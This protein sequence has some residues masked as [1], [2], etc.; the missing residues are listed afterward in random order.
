MKLK[1][2]T[3]VKPGFAFH[4]AITPD[5]EGAI[6]VVQ[7]RDAQVGQDFIQAED[8]VKISFKP[9]RT[10]TY[11]LGGDIILT[12]RGTGVGAFRAAV[13]EFN[14]DD[15]NILPSSSVF[16]I[17]IKDMQKLMPQFLALFLNSSNGQRLILQTASGS[18]VQTISRREL[19]Q[20]DL[21]IPPLIVQKN[22]VALADNILKQEQISKRKN[23]LKRD[24]INVTIS[25][26]THNH[27]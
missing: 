22:L 7:A 24:L 21:S 16:V 20:I 5:E 26:L 23:Q 3:E 4:G 18:N 11:V 10:R 27:N 8:L 19:E 1:D 17:R 2:I 6:F 14:I 15:C 13:M 9:V 25:N 12:A